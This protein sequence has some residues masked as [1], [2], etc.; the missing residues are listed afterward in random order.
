M[1]V[2]H[3]QLTTVM[4]SYG[5]SLCSLDALRMIVRTSRSQLGLFKQTATSIYKS[6]SDGTY[7]HGCSISIRAISLRMF[8]MYP[9]IKTT[10]IPAHRMRILLTPFMNTLAIITMFQNSISHCNG[11]DGI[12]RKIILIREKLKIIIVGRVKFPSTSYDITNYCS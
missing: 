1:L 9:I 10:A 6:P 5:Y 7:P 8:T 4:N 2:F 11:A 12:I 3:M